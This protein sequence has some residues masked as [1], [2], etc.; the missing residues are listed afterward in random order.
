MPDKQWSIPFGFI[1]SR[2]VFFFFTVNKRIDWICA[3]LPGKINV[4]TKRSSQRIKHASRCS[5]HRRQQHSL[6]QEHRRKQ[7]RI[8]DWILHFYETPE[9]LPMRD[10]ARRSVWAA[11]HSWTHRH[12]FFSQNW[13]RNSKAL[14]FCS[15]FA[16]IY[17]SSAGVQ[18][19][20]AM[21]I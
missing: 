16:V 17:R 8:W 12:V 4:Y 10:T 1:I 15:M 11:R 3:L 18:G 2:F 21:W 5:P 6:Q 9:A 14:L 7:M 13:G 20:R 19:R